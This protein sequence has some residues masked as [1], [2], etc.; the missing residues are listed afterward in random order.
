MATLNASTTG[1]FSP[2]GHEFCERLCNPGSLQ[3]V[4]AHLNCM[5]GSNDKD[6]IIRL[7]IINVR[8]LLAYCGI[9]CARTY[10]YQ[11]ANKLDLRIS[12]L[13]LRACCEIDGFTN[14]K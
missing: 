5:I 13:F 2:C 3:R 9:Q 11:L 10:A 6:Y 8:E 12:M 14:K 1:Y 4:S 7:I